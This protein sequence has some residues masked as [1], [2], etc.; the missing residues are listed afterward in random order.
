MQ[1]SRPT[2]IFA[3]NDWSAIEVLIGA[4]STGVAIPTELSVVGF[5]DTTLARSGWVSLTTVGYSRAEMGALAADLVRNRL[6]KLD[7]KP[8]R[9]TLRPSLLARLTT[10]KP[11]STAMK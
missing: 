8:Q 4:R 7:A 5:D 6:A 11:R 1:Q 3:A 9:V 2:A 10:A